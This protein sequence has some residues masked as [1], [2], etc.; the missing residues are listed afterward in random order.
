MYPIRA[1][2]ASSTLVDSRVFGVDEMLVALPSR[3]RESL[4]FRFSSDDMMGSDS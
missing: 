3:T 1:S 4:A 2:S